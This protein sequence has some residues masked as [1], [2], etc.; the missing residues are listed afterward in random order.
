MLSFKSFI[1]E[2]LED[3]YGKSVGIEELSQHLN[4]NQMKN[5]M[6]HE[7]HKSYTSYGDNPTTYKV[8]KHP[9]LSDDFSVEASHG[10]PR[11]KETFG[12]K[13]DVRHMVQFHFYKNKIHNADLFHNRGDQKHH[14]TGE[15]MWEWKRSHKN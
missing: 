14:K 10:T 13:E 9:T 5:L 6:N 2:K 11:N 1:T 4:K 12:D 15:R 3:I 7:W 8:S